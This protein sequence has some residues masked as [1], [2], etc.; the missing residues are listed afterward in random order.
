[1]TCNKRVVCSVREFQEMACLNFIT[2]SQDWA[3]TDLR[4]SLNSGDNEGAKMMKKDALGGEK[5][6]NRGQEVG[7]CPMCAEESSRK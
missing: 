6:T 1:M 3:R 7:M 2:S 5:H 4:K